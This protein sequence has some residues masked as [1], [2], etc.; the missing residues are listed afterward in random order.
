MTD[1]RTCPH[2]DTEPVHGY[3]HGRDPHIGDPVWPLNDSKPLA[4]ICTACHEQLPTGWGCT[5]C[6]W[7]EAPR[8]LCDP[9]NSTDLVLARPCKQHT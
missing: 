8:R 1:P 3:L 9:V 2:T 4:R 5:D 6:E 7:V